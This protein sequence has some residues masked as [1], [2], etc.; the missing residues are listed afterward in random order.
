MFVCDTE[1]LFE[2][3]LLGE[4]AVCSGFATEESLKNALQEAQAGKV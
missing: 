2:L 4:A 1:G 3:I